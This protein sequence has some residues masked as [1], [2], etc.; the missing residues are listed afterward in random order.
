[1]IGVCAIGFA[2]QLGLTASFAWGS[3]YGICGLLLFALLF[4]N[5]IRR[6]GA[7]TLPEY[8][9]MRYDGKVRSVVA[10]TSVVGMSGI[11]ANNIVSCTNAIA[12]FT[13]WNATLIMAVIFLVIIAFTFI[14]GLWATTLTDF[15]QVTLG[16][17]IVP[18][19]LSLIHI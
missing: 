19:I 4:S 3:I 13:K 16:V 6:C 12:G 9:E 5:F 8:L 11:L 17:I 15:F 10:I 1:M 18:T 2:V 14:S 7:Q